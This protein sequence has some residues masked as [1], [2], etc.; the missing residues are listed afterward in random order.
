MTDALWGFCLLAL[1]RLNKS[2]Q[3]GARWNFSARRALQ[4]HEP[5]EL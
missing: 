3:T 1:L 4:G 2:A 5:Y